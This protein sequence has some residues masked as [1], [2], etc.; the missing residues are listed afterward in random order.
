M[1]EI[2]DEVSVRYSSS[3]ELG[4]TSEDLGI[5]LDNRA[6][7]TLEQLPEL[8]DCEPRVADD[9]R[10]RDGVDRI[11][12]RDGQDAM[13]VTH[14]DVPSLA[15]DRKTCLLQSTNGGQMGYARKLGHGATR[16][17]TEERI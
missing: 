5:R 14:D 11:M 12:A 3:G 10:H 8:L 7:T 16:S 6:R 9:T 15:H 1:L 13:T 17:R 2:V 4:F